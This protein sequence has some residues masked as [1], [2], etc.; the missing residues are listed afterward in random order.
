MNVGGKS[1]SRLGPCV[2]A[3]CLSTLW[4]PAQAELPVRDQDPAPAGAPSAPSSAAEKKPKRIFRTG[5]SYETADAATPISAAGK[6]RIF[7]GYAYNPLN[8]A[9][10]GLDAGIGQAR[11]SPEPYGQGGEGFGKRFGASLAD[12]SSAVFFGRFMLATLLRQ[13][14]RYFRRAGGS[15]GSRTGY[16]LSR[17][18]ITR[19][20]DGKRQSNYSLL[21]G[22]LFSGALSNAYYPDQSRG[23]GLTFSRFGFGLLGAAAAN[24]GHEFWPDARR[25]MFRGKTAAP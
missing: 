3:F 6:F 24:L 18:L 7:S 13:D 8:W 5:R 10:A 12:Q 19:S 14:P 2:L 4:Q 22:A 9:V 11:N 17:V 20:D 21:G 25:K 1:T 16:A 23:A 15:F